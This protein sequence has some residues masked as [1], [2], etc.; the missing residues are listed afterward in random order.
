MIL[1]IIL[2]I[3]AIGVAYMQYLQGLF[4]AAI[5]LG[6][7]VVATLVAFGYYENAVNAMGQNGFTDY[8][9]GMMLIVIFAITYI[10]L[11]V[12][13]DAVVPG[14]VAVPLYVDKVGSAACGLG[15]GILT[16]GVFGTGLQLMPFGPSV[17][18][19]APYPLQDRSVIVPA[20]AAGKSR[21]IDTF[22]SDELAVDQFHDRGGLLLPVDTLTTAL[23]K[24]ASDGAF[25]GGQAFSAVHPDLQAEGFN[26]RVGA[27]HSAKRVA[28]NS[29]KT[30]S[31][32][33]P[34]VYTLTGGF[35][36]L[37]TE[38]PD[39]RDKKQSLTFK[40]S[41]SDTLLVVRVAFGDPAADKDGMARLT[42]AAARLVIGDETFYPIGS[43]EGSSYLGLNRLDDLLAVTFAGNSRAIDLVYDL[44]KAAFDKLVAATPGSETP[45]FIEAKLYGRVDLSGMKPGDYKA[46]AKTTKIVRKATSPLGLAVHPPKQPS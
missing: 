6:C 41:A 44:P 22:A 26:S 23:V 29:K 28:L 24:T 3:A 40:P 43:M 33:V 12:I 14:N 21:G 25:S 11:R 42:P 39:I 37:D 46:A 31:V 4:T 1:S 27:E 45:A 5:S 38:V 20:S 16:A 10:V 15:A 30:Q 19:Y 2:I 35:T 17:A 7:A 9:G 34:G 18:G 13:A 36:A 32:T 8:A